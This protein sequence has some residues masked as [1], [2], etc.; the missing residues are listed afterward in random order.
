M[1]KLFKTYDLFDI[2]DEDTRKY[3]LLHCLDMALRCGLM[4]KCHLDGIN[5]R[6]HMSGT[7]QQFVKY[8]L[9]TLMFN[10][11][12]FDGLKRLMYIITW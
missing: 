7:K 6:L 5:T 3:C 9:K 11:P 8:Y 10:K 4:C 1:T 2:K 12:F